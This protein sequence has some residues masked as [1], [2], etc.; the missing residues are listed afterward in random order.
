MI[1]LLN[2]KHINKKV[3]GVRVHHSKVQQYI[4]LITIELQ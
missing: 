1:G 4:V 2:N 3:F